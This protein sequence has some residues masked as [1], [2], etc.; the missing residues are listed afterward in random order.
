MQYIFVELSIFYYHILNIF[1]CRCRHE[2]ITNSW[3]TWCD[4]WKLKPELWCVYT[5]MFKLH[6]GSR[7]GWKAWEAEISYIIESLDQMPWKFVTLLNGE[8]WKRKQPLQFWVSL[9]NILQWFMVTFCQ[10][11]FLGPIIQ[12]L[13]HILVSGTHYRVSGT[14]CSLWDPL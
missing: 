7:I 12:S 13:G 6:S 2:F 14:H 4:W 1:T 8:A 5:K 3:T 10:N 9:K 11:G